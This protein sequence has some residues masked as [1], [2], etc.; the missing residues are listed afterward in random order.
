MVRAVGREIV[1]YPELLQVTQERGLLR[2][3]EATERE[4]YLAG[5]FR[6]EFGGTCG[7]SLQLPFNGHDASFDSIEAWL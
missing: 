3:I 2:G 7:A 5:I 1:I 4:L 6:E